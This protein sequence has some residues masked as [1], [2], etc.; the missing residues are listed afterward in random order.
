[1]LPNNE[2]ITE[3]IKEEVKKKKLEEL[4]LWCKGISILG[5]TGMQV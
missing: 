1:M 3:E 2:W 4:L 5:V